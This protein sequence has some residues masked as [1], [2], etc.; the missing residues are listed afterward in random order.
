MSLIK[1]SLRQGYIGNLKKVLL[2]FRLH[3][4]SPVIDHELDYS[5]V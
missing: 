5:G 2:K 1:I 3:D 4:L